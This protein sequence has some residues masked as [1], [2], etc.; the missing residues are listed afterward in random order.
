MSSSPPDS[1]ARGGETRRTRVSPLWL[2]ALI[3][4]LPLLVLAVIEAAAVVLTAG[5]RALTVGQGFAA[6]QLATALTLGV[7]LAL[8][9]VAYATLLVLVW[10]RIIVWRH[11]GQERQAT[12]ALFALALTALVVLLPVVLALLIPQHPAP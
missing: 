5:A 4:L 1:P 3:G 7:G 2:G 9:F 11:A 8:G 6:E 10:R 12:G